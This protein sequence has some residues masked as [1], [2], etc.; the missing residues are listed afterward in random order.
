M[1]RVPDWP[2]LPASIHL[3]RVAGVVQDS[4][5]LF[6]AVH[7]GGSPMICLN[8]DGTLRRTVGAGVH[9]KSVA[10]LWFK[11]TIRDKMEELYFLHGLHVDPWDNVWVTDIGRH[12]VMRFDPEGRLTLTLGV[13][14]V[15]GCDETHFNQPTHACVAPTGEIFVTDGYGNAR[16]VKF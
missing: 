16:V 1:V 4:R 14:G 5:G 7:R 15:P 9:R 10:F 2:K 11:G 6:Y 13:D 8:P 3:D 12:L